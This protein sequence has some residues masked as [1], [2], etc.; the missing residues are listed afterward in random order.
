MLKIEYIWRELLYRAIE[1]KKTHFSL[2]E[3]AGRFNLSTSVVSHALK[4]LRDLNIVK[5]GKLQSIL[6]DTERL[7]FFWATRRNLKKDIVY[8]TYSPLLIFEREIS[9]P[10]D[11]FPTAYSACRL[12]YNLTP[13][14]Y[15][16]VYFYADNGDEIKKRFPLNSKKPPNLFILK[17]DAYL[18]QY[19]KITIAQIF[20]DLWNLPEW[21]AKDFQEVVL[22]KIKGEIGL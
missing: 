22:L 15:E 3:L 18:L 4:P 2:Q 13:A 10:S 12:Y 20:V 6:I 8:A 17:P 1:K 19:K 14:D 5:I 7:L 9:M 16:D 11:V 21:Y